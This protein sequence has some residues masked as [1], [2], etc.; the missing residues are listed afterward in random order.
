MGLATSKG[1]FQGPYIEAC[2]RVRPYSVP[3]VWLQCRCEGFSEHLFLVSR[4]FLFFGA[5][6]EGFIKLRFG[7][8]GSYI[9]HCVVSVCSS[10]E[11]E[12]KREQERERKRE[13]ERERERDRER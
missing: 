3:T 12:R 4:T 6:C 13:R 1:M 10:G 9:E 5:A 2:V 7:V 11:R 8:Q